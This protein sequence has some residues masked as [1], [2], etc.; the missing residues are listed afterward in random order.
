M[1]EVLSLLKCDTTKGQIRV[2]EK[3]IWLLIYN[4]NAYL[5]DITQCIE[6]DYYTEE[7]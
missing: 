5:P 4:W 1:L 7:N 3:H 2:G 6:E